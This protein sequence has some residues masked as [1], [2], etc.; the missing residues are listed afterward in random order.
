MILVSNYQSN[1]FGTQFAHGMDRTLYIYQQYALVVVDLVY[2]SVW[3][4]RKEVLYP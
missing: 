4:V 2:N 1:I 3:V